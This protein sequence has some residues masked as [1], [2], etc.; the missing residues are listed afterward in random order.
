L[1]KVPLITMFNVKS[2]SGWWTS[3]YPRVKM[4]KVANHPYERGKEMFNKKLQRK[5]GIVIAIVVSFAMLITLIPGG[6]FGTTAPQNQNLVSSSNN[7]S[8]LKTVVNSLEQRVEQS[9]ENVELRLELANTYYDLGNLARESAPDEVQGYFDKA[10]SHYEEVLKTKSNDVNILVDAATV[11][12]NSTGPNAD[13]L[14]SLIAQAQEL[15]LN[16]KLDAAAGTK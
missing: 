11:A 5:V 4:S 3:K 6:F 12:K 16:A 2:V 15:E 10:V 13:Y 9:P 14:K 7:Y 1:G 8:N